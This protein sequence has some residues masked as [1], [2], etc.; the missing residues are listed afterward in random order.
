MFEVSLPTQYVKL[1]ERCK[2]DQS[3]VNDVRK[4]YCST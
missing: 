1:G 3:I 2:F 4:T